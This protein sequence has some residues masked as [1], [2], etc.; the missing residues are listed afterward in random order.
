MLKGIR[1]EAAVILLL[2]L[3]VVT[4]ALGVGVGTA[5]LSDMD[6]RRNIIRPGDSNL[7]IEEEFPAPGPL[8]PGKVIAKRVQIA[9]KGKSSCFVRCRLLLDNEEV[10]PYLSYGLDTDNWSRGEDGYYYYRY[11]IAKGGITTELLKDITVSPDIPREIAERGFTL[12]VY[13]ESYQ[14]G[15]FAETAWQEAWE[16]FDRNRKGGGQGA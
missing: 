16:H 6:G 5:Y 9:N 12:N 15:I 3:A 2:L 11:A 8:T 1:K 4:A 10:L 13:A 7:E 14:Q